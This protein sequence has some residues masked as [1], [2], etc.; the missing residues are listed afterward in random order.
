[1]RRL[2]LHGQALCSNTHIHYQLY[3]IQLYSYF[4]RDY[5]AAIN[6]LEAINQSGDRIQKS[7]AKGT[8]QIIYGKFEII[9]LTKIIFDCMQ[10]FII[11]FVGLCVHLQFST[12]LRKL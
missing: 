8:L 7:D 12:S 11:S 6:D 2:Q 1:M 3:I 4:S 5:L 10:I 9:A